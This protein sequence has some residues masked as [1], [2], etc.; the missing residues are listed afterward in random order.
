MLKFILNFLNKNI[1]NVARKIF[2]TQVLQKHTTHI[3]C[4]V[5]ILGKSPIY[6]DN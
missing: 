4:P 1:W 6:L 5:H 2:W 3:D